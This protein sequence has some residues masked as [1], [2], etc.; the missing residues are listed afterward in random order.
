LKLG[1]DGWEE[2]S[3]VTGSKVGLDNVVDDVLELR[4]IIVNRID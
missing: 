4:S 3:P 1:S 2:T